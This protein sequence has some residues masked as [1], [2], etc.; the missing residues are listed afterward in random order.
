MIDYW[1]HYKPGFYY[2]FIKSLL[3]SI[4]LFIIPLIAFAHPHVFVD[5]SITVVF[6]QQGLA[7]FH[8]HWV[9]DRMFSGNMLSSFAPGYDPDQL[10]LTPSDIKSIKKGAFDSLSKFNYFQHI[11]IQNK[12]FSNIVA[13]DF[14]AKATHKGLVYNFFIP[15]YLKA[16]ADSSLIEMSVFDDSFYTSIQVSSFMISE[17]DS[18][19]ITHTIGP[20]NY[21]KYYMGQITPTGISLKFNNHLNSSQKTKIENSIIMLTNEQEQGVSLWQRISMR[22]NQWQDY[23]KDIMTDFGNEMKKNFWGKSLYLFIFF[24]FLYGIVHALGPGHGKSIVTSY[25]IARPGEYY[26]GIL[27]A[28]VLSITHALSGAI[29]VLVMTFIFKSPVLF[30]SAMPVERVSYALLIVIGLVLFIHGII[31]ALKKD[32]EPSNHDIKQLLI[33]AITTGMI[34]CPG[35][36]IILI[37]SISINFV[38]I[39]MM[40]LLAMGIGMGFTTSIFALVAIFSRN[41]ISSMRRFS[42]RAYHFFHTA[43]SICGAITIILF[44][45]VLFFS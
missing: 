6:D 43:L 30:A 34:P 22:V 42:Q 3:I 18:L 13:Q 41:S 45:V 38:T 40:A 32:K 7:G 23:I 15:C 11:R 24:S 8:N 1:K 25:F 27:M 10:S 35:A 4:V 20:L 16:S 28:F 36:A 17:S 9:M 39:G 19:D 29:F 31:D 44:G 2:K 14:M 5:C 21:F 33:V 37:F 12:D 26:L